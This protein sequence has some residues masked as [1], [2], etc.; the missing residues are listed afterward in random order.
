MCTKAGSLPE[1]GSSN[2]IFRES[3][4]A[5]P[6]AWRHCLATFTR[7]PA[8]PYLARL[9][10]GVPWPLTGPVECVSC[11]MVV[12]LGSTQLSGFEVRFLVSGPRSRASPSCCGD[13]ASR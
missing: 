3:K 11:P 10:V 2:A 13:S 12:R 1:V 4:C 7:L 5:P 9:P 8:Q 6:L